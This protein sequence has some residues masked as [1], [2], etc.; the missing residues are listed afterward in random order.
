LWPSLSVSFRA[1]LL[2]SDPKTFGASVNISTVVILLLGLLLVLEWVKRSALARVAALVL[3]L[4]V[5][6]LIQPVSTPAYRRAV[7]TQDR[8]VEWGPPSGRFPVSEYVSGVLTMNREVR[9][10][11]D[12]LY[13][14]LWLGTSVLVWLA[15]SPLFRRPRNLAELPKT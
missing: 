10:E 14:R 4:L 2:T 12:H 8:V 15:I 13:D 5:L 7:A 6:P 3:A 1:K 11:L 9:K